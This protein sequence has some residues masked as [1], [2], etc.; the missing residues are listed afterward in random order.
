MDCLTLPSMVFTRVRRGSSLSPLVVH[1]AEV[2]RAEAVDDEAAAYGPDVDKPE[3]KYFLRRFLVLHREGRWE[4]TLKAW[5]SSLL[6]LDAPLAR[7]LLEEQ[8]ANGELVRFREGEG[9]EIRVGIDAA[10]VQP[11]REEPY[12][13]RVDFTETL[14][15]ATGRPAPKR[16][17][18]RASSEREGLPVDPIRDQPWNEGRIDGTGCSMRLRFLYN[19]PLETGPPLGP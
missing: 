6:F 1:I 10:Q 11:S 16:R 9:T 12:R 18:R 13:V 4:S 3:A 5:K 17:L 14:R 7:R 2:G 15:A 8:E 19:S